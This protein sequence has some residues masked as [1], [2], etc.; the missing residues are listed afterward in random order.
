ML[1]DLLDD[2]LDSQLWAHRNIDVLDLGKQEVLLL[3]C[4]DL[5]EEVHWT[6]LQSGKKDLSYREL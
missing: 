5:L 3:T 4:E 1:P 2:P 6:V